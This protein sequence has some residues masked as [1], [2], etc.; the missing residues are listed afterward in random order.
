MGYMIPTATEFHVFSVLLTILE[1]IVLL[2]SL[3][4]CA[5]HALKSGWRPCRKRGGPESGLVAF[6]FIHFIYCVLF[7]TEGIVQSTV[8]G[9][10]CR[11][12]ANIYGPLWAAIAISWMLFLYLFSQHFEKVFT[13]NELFEAC[14]RRRRLL[15]GAIIVTIIVTKA[16]LLPRF[17]T[18]PVLRCVQHVVTSVIADQF[19]MSVV[20]LFELCRLLPRYWRHVHRMPNPT[21]H[22]IASIVILGMCTCGSFIATIT[23]LV[24][25][26]SP[27]YNRNANL[28]KDY[29]DDEIETLYLNWVAG[30]I[31]AFFTCLLPVS[32]TT[33]GLTFQTNYLSAN[34]EVSEGGGDGRLT[35]LVDAEA[36]EAAGAAAQQPTMPLSTGRSFQE[37]ET[38]SP[39]FG[40][41][42]E[43]AQE[44][45]VAADMAE[46]LVRLSQPRTSQINI[47]G[48]T[49][50]AITITESLAP[51][52]IA[53]PIVRLFLS[54][55]ALPFAEAHRKRHK[56]EAKM[57]LELLNPERSRKGT[58]NATAQ[59]EREYHMKKLGDKLS[60]V[61]GE[62]DDWLAVLKH[63]V[64]AMQRQAEAEESAGEIVFK[65][66]KS[67][68]R[69]GVA[70]LP[71]NLQ[72]HRFRLEC[73]NTKSVET[74]CMTY[75]APAAHVFKF[76]GGGLG[77]AEAKLAKDGQKQQ[78]EKRLLPDDRVARLRLKF[79]AA[80]RACVAVSQAMAA[81]VAAAVDSLEDAV[82][83]RGTESQADAENR[84]AMWRN[85][86]LLVHEVSLLSTHGKEEGM[87]DDMASAL[88]RLRVT[89]R[90]VPPPSSSDSRGNGDRT[91]FRVMD[92][93]S[94]TSQQE[95]KQQQQLDAAQLGSL[96]V[97]LSVDSRDTFEWLAA[98][99]H[100]DG[101]SSEAGFFDIDICPVLITLGVNEFQ[102]VANATN[103]TEVQTRVN[104]KGVQDLERYHGAFHAFRQRRSGS[105][106]DDI[107]GTNDT[108][109]ECG[110]LLSTL[111]ELVEKEAAARGQ[112]K[113]VNV[114]L[115]SSYAARLMHGARTTSC[116][117]AKDRTSM[118][119]SLESVRWAQRQG[120]LSV[121]SVETQN[122]SLQGEQEGGEN[123]LMVK[124]SGSMPQ[125]EVQLLELLRGAQGVRLQNCSDNIGKAKYTFNSLQ[126]GQLPLELR[127]LGSVSG[128]GQS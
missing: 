52:S 79:V 87:I 20:A 46:G 112:S 84:V 71:T 12:Q 28:N 50:G 89:L 78:A 70:M 61:S 37:S 36:A 69:V 124:A 98:C 75:G 67:K 104:R 118:F 105:S 86:G 115:V 62:V 95:E 27:Q 125:E 96:L 73:N 41:H 97:T 47:Q 49:S 127:P 45:A 99:S 106:D 38:Q 100:A 6:H 109:A 121:G 65:P 29:N 30:V 53:F 119:Q 31:A 19:S 33:L 16:A 64:V 60:E 13:T 34:L 76:K 14:T 26:C 103:A 80:G 8:V 3:G 85:I 59:L 25:L 63:T 21:W 122:Q 66:S 91:Q 82:G 57:V 128:A 42:H 48:I 7:C 88:D 123:Q 58:R 68:G 111:G 39:L 2:L 43:A 23:L 10:E 51:P 77:R 92:V 44:A 35:E 110:R 81:T 17:R 90:V 24:R 117:S 74:T 18:E 116:K 56:I 126:L 113:I 5:H 11:V 4:A 1:W 40:A 54:Q 107:G 9:G 108:A 32:Y 101:T 93:I 22:D 15:Y 94:K 114:L 55:V 102:T 83:G 72:R 120:V